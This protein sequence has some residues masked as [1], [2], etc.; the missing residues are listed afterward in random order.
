VTQEEKILDQIIAILVLMN[1]YVPTTA[2][3]ANPQ[4][5]FILKQLAQL[6]A[7]RT[8]IKAKFNLNFLNI[9]EITKQI[10]SL[11]IK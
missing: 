3:P 9:A 7:N 8:A 1:S 5:P 4:L 2:N 6:Q 11:N 10:T